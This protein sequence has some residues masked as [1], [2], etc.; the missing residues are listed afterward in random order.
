M[1]DN[2][3][4]TKESTTLAVLA[5]AYAGGAKKEELQWL[6]DSLTFESSRQM[7]NDLF[8]GKEGPLRKYSDGTK[9]WKPIKS[10]QHAPDNLRVWE[11]NY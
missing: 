3:I 10:F 7:A 1:S 11:E 9:N 6:I 8:D 2:Q 5:Q 4:A